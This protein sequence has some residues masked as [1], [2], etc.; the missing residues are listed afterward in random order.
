MPKHAALVLLLS[1]AARAQSPVSVAPNS[2]ATGASMPTPRQGPATGVIGQKIYVIGGLNSS[3]V[4]NLNE[5][6]DPAMDSWTTAAP[7]P[8]ARFVPASAVVNNILYA[9]GGSSSETVL[10]VVE[11]YNPSTDTWSTKSPMPISANSVYAVIEN[12]IIYVVGGFSAGA[13][14][15]TVLSY[16]PATDRW[17]TLAPMMVAK[18]QPAV[19][20]LGS[21][22]VAAGGLANG[23]ITTTDNEGYDSASNSWKT[24]APLPTA[25]F[26]GCFE[27]SGG[28]LY[29]TGGLG[30]SGPP[31]ASMDAYNASTDSW[32]SGLPPLPTAVTDPASAS[33]NGRLYC[34]GGSTTNQAGSGANN[35]V[36]I[37]QPATIP[38]ISDVISAS[39]FGGF[40]SVAPGSWIEIYG[41]ALASETRGWTG[42]DFNGLNAPTALDKT[43]V[44]I[45][46][47]SAFIDY[48]SPGQVNVQVP[49]T[50]GTGTQPVVVTT[51][52]GG[53]APYM[54]AVNATQ[55]GLLSPTSFNI[56][57]IQ[58]AVALFSDGVTYVLPAGAIPGIAS[59]PAKPGDTITLYGV[60]FGPVTPNIPAGQI[61]GETNALLGSLHVFFG[62]VAATL[63]YAGLA[64]NFVGLYQFDVV[65]PDVPAGNATPLTFTLDGTPGTQTL[66]L[67]VG[68]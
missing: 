1:F 58:Y 14:L 36:Q 24:L 7:M 4:L 32:T 57:G 16:N 29:F 33:L 28:I 17:S 10:N 44:T 43:S 26:Q 47:Q 54:V 6:Y 22:I 46:G 56:G 39:G 51:A 9:M 5:V 62:G 45:G 34:F 38:S 40:S 67:A 20:L 11:A 15:S 53:S 21:T 64:P 41:T 35:Y 12:G 59:Q 50:V 63:P 25:R 3:G 61:V 23:S 52:E 48:I 55:P 13:R 30:A 8:T 66:A 68:S 27:A 60:G 49:S 42:A 37:Y 18:S 19:A 31:L 2:W 65:V